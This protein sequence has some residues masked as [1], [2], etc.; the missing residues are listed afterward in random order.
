MDLQDHRD[1]VKDVKFAPVGS[2]RLA[3][4]S[5]DGTVK[6]WDL[7]DCGNM[8]KTLKHGC[9]WVYSVAWSPNGV[10]LAAAGDTRQVASCRLATFSCFAVKRCT[11][12]SVQYHILITPN[13]WPLIIMCTINSPMQNIVCKQTCI[14]NCFT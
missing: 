13:Y 14:M 12:I 9:K 7:L 10:L 4:C 2:Y 11:C 6:L 3:S 5:R 8:Y 1:V